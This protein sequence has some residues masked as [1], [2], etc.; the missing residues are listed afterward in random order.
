MRRSRTIG[1]I[2][3]RWIME[4]ASSMELTYQH[5][6]CGPILAHAPCSNACM[7][8]QTVKNGEY[9]PDTQATTF[10]SFVRQE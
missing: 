5:P 1:W 9:V 3:V 6:V 10:A 4:D 8:R 2:C 7:S